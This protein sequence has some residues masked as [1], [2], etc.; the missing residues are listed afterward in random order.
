MLSWAK[1]ATARPGDRL[2]GLFKNGKTQLFNSRGIVKWAYF[3][4]KWSVHLRLLDLIFLVFLFAVKSSL[5]ISCHFCSG[6]FIEVNTIRKAT[7]PGNQPTIPTCALFFPCV[8]LEPFRL[9]PVKQTARRPPPYSSPGSPPAML[10][11]L[12]RFPTL[13][14]KDR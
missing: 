5:V 4:K 3:Q 10:S 7:Y 2:N 6:W 1:S 13:Q 8:S 11:H 12:A 14:P 9:Y